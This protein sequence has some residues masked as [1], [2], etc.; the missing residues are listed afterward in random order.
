MAAKKS[1]GNVFLDIG[2]DQIESQELAVKSDLITLLAHYIRVRKLTQA[3]AAI[4]CGTDQPTLS[5]VLSGRHNAVT[6]D[7]LTRW[8]VALGGRIR[9]SVS[10]PRPGQ[11]KPRIGMAVLQR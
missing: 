6:I 3:E 9:I 1:S 11:S 4:L 8:L 2:F 7:R 10:R 5:K